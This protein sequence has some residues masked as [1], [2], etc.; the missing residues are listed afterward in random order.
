M[1]HERARNAWRSIR[2]CL[3]TLALG[4]ASTVSR[5]QVPD[6]PRE[7][8][9][10]P[11]AAHDVPFPAFEMRTLANGLQVVALVHHEQPVVSLRMLVR[12]GSAS[13]PAGKGGVASLVAAL[14]DQGTTSR[15]ADAIA[16]AIDSAGGTLDTSAGAD[17]TS[18]SV[19]VM[20]DEFQLGLD[21]LS[22]V[23]RN[24][25]FDSGAMERQR[26]RNLS[27]LA[28]R[29]EDPDYLASVVLD[30]L[31]FGS[32]PYG[33]PNAG[34][35]DTVARITRD[36]LRAFHSRYV[37]PNN[38][39]LAVV[40]DIDPAAALAAAG[41]TF[42][43]WERREIERSTVMEPPPPAARVL[44]VNKP[45]AVQTEIRVG[46]LAVARANPD[47]QA[48]DLAIKILG[49]EGS[50]RLHRV[51]RTE[52]GLTYG[53]EAD[54][55]ALGET[56]DFVARTSTRTESTGEVLRLIVDEVARLR[57]ER[58]TERELADAQAYLA[59]SFPLTIETPDQIA[60][61]VLTALF[62]HLPLA[63][64]AKYRERI[65]AITPEDIERV[66]L[67]YLQPDRLSVVL[68]G[69]AAGFVGQLAGL[70]FDRYEMVNLGELDVSSA[71]FRR[72]ERQAEATP[73]RTPPRRRTAGAPRQLP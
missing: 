7:N 63:D 52:R 22:D 60:A 43:G 29:N 48:A 32:H 51:L 23:V 12:A 5:A 61:Q 17:V 62:Y 56:G 24:P 67:R 65:N 64:L 46:Q 35:A 42:E 1:Q 2:C 14:L 53:A 66:A 18:A 45:D 58:V 44:I 20:K 8:P 27:A 70:G 6:W 10:A 54:L 36:D 16:D 34:T 59:G 11:L 15:S 3:I 50:N 13:D 33:L 41:R 31:V 25:A 30:R 37:V 72:R 69:N 39:I 21:L 26:R 4:A 57:R 28:V 71:D 47:F 73:R 40:G 38:A 19:V 49:G 9:P 68:V 55:D